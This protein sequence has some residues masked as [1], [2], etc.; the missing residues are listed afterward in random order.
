M[1]PIVI[2]LAD[3][4]H[5]GSCIAS[6]QVPL[7]IGLIGAYAK[8]KFGDQ[9]SIKLFK[10]PEKLLEAIKSVKPDILAVS[11]YAW[12]YNLAEWACR[13]V[14]EIDKNIL[15]VKGGWN[16][17]L[18]DEG[19]H[20]FLETYQDTDI[21]VVHE[22]ELVFSALLD[23]YLLTGREG[24][25]SSRIAGTCYLDKKQKRLIAG[26][27][28]P[29]IQTLDSIPSPYLNGML[30]E[31][32]DGSLIP[33]VETTRGCPYRCNYCNSAIENYNKVRRF[34]FNYLKSDFDY[35]CSM[36]KNTQN[37]QIMIPDANFG[38]FKQ[39]KKI[40][41]LLAD[42]RET[43]DWPHIV[44]VVGSGKGNQKFV[45]EALAPIKDSVSPSL[46]F[47][48]FNQKTL[49]EIKRKN[50]ITTEFDVIAKKASEIG[51]TIHS[52]LIAPLPYESLVS[53]LSGLKNLMQCGPKK[54]TTY[55]LQ[56]NYGTLYRDTH[57]L[58]KHGIVTKYRPIIN[59]S[60]F[61]DGEFVM[62]SEAVAVATN[63]MK[64]EEYITVRCFA[65]YT[66]IIYNNDIFCE[67]TKLLKES[68]YSVYDLITI[69]HEE[70]QNLDGPI[71]QVINSFISDTKTEL[72]DSEKD[73]FDFYSVKENYDG[74]LRGEIGANVIFKHKSWIISEH[75][76]L[77]SK[78]VTFC[79]KKIYRTKAD[80]FP[81]QDSEIMFKC[82]MKF[83]EC[84][85]FDV[86]DDMSMDTPILYT[87]E[88]DVAGW[89]EDNDGLS[90][91]MFRRNS[92]TEFV[93]TE[94]QKVMKKNLFTQYGLT[95]V[96][97]NKILAKVALLQSLFRQPASITIG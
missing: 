97:K 4:T 10:F 90:L 30:D 57:Y 7:N 39:D 3:L 94:K 88:Y 86:F 31:F 69:I 18:D 89:M 59:A 47:Q 46:A 78:F 35:I 2:Y 29:D 38:M 80:V 33:I 70:L 93:Y 67:I 24:V 85:L 81:L 76:V 65:F 84:K 27:R 63:D 52:E 17:P 41:E 1:K 66:E 53:Y 12:N 64:F 71:K 16:F 55:T 48:S 79:A 54:I 8:K 45:L 22:G 77:L 68:G 75:I 40:A 6:E 44:Y 25:L 28:M 26:E 37:R 21:Y 11:N 72:S 60:G 19:Q 95:P 51:F 58:N 9:I 62:E 14:K 87:G 96:G 43:K 91:S 82:I 36:L 34:S 49:T 20:Q 56:L 61:Y 15:T 50:I 73:V 32:L 5:T 23:V 92:Q 42:M 13:K 83:I 74:M